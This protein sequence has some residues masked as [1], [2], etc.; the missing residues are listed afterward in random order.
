MPNHILITGASGLI[1]KQLT[2][3]LLSKNHKVSH[4]GRSVKKGA[5]PS[6]QWD[7]EK[8]YIDPRALEGIDTII[9]LAGAGVSDHR[10]SEEWKK[11]ILESRT[12]S[13]RLLFETLKQ[14]KHQVKNVIAAS[15]IGIYGFTM[16]NQLYNEESKP[17]DDFLAQ[18]VRAWEEEVDQIQSLGIRV[19]KIRI[20]IVLSEKGGALK[21]MAKP[22]KL[23]VGSPLA[24]GKQYVSWIHI[25]DLCGIFAKAV[26]DNR[27]TGA[28]N[29]VAPRAVTNKE[30]TEAMAK[31]LH[32]PLWIPSVPAFV[33]KIVVGEMANIVINGSNVSAE[34]VEEAGYAFRFKELSEALKDLL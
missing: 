13:S 34:K 11:E 14:G 9:H 1:G 32:R 33:L 21:Q 27:M 24:T 26:E 31:A 16:S 7:I 17:G 15:A 3:L 4:L 19:V 18:V 8:K 25:D 28:Y 30:I 5:V 23:F 20:G 22:V 12:H 2:E 10:W 6:Y 29:A